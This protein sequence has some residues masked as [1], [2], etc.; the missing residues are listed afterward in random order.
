MMD[1][2]KQQILSDKVYDLLIERFDVQAKSREQF[3]EEMERQHQAR[4]AVTP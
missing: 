1:R 4:Q 3:E 2:V